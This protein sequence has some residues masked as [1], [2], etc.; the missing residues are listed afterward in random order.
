[1]NTSAAWFNGRAGVA[2]SVDALIGLLPSRSAAVLI[3]GLAVIP[4][5]AQAENWYAGVSVGQSEADI[6][7]CDLDISCSKDETDTGVKVFAGYQ[8]NPNGAFEFGY[9]DLGK[10][11]ASGVDSFFGN[12]S[13]DWEASGFTATV[14][15]TLPVNQNFALMGKLGIFFWDLDI[16]ARASFFGSGSDSDSGTDL[17]YG[18][19]VKYDFTKTF[20][21]RA[22]WERFQDVG[23]NS[24][25]G[26][27]DIDLFSVGVVFKF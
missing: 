22:E 11:K 26:Q 19:G 16:H 1:V 25:T 20:G 12:A 5:V 9:V 3:L 21:M 8:F 14:V 23:D 10:F 2:S 24:T 6:G 15:G 7:A 27:S 13:I 17:T 4:T 18:L